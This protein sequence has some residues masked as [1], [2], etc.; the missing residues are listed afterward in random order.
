MADRPGDFDPRG[1]ARR[2]VPSAAHLN[3]ARLTQS[4]FAY[5]PGNA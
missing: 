1:N 2:P 4:F 3:P 5:P